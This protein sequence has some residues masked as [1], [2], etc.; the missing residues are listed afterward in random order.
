ME[1]KSNLVIKIIVAALLLGAVVFYIFSTESSSIKEVSNV[2]ETTS[3]TEE[4]SGL[5]AEDININTPSVSN[6]NITALSNTVSSLSKDIEELSKTISQLEKK[7]ESLEK[8]LNKTQNNNNNNNSNNW[9]DRLIPS[10]NDSSKEN[11]SN[12]DSKTS[13]SPYGEVSVTMKAK[14]ENRYVE[15][16]NVPNI[17]KG[18]TGTVIIDIEVNIIGTV[19]KVSLNPNSTL[20]HEQ[21]VDLCKESA[22]KTDFSYNPEANNITRGTITYTFKEK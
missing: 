8:D 21:V 15:I 19:T 2:N 13:N 16:E 4:P 1:D 20:K 9:L 22:L 11:N 18:P 17:G 6:D 10:K 3:L 7:V 14:V 12:E 5:E